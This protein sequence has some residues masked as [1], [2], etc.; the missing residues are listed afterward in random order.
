MIY[1]LRLGFLE[2]YMHA[3]HIEEQAWFKLSVFIG[4]AH[5]SQGPLTSDP[6]KGWGTLSKTTNGLTHYMRAIMR[7]SPYYTASSDEFSFPFH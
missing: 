7:V 1:P 6:A 5:Y 2:L 4:H 3:A